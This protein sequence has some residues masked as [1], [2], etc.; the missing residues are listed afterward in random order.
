MAAIGDV[1]MYQSLYQTAE[2]TEFRK[3]IYSRD[4]KCLHVKRFDTF[5]LILDLYLK[6]AR[7]SVKEFICEVHKLKPATFRSSVTFKESN[8]GRVSASADTHRLTISL[9][10]IP[11]ETSRK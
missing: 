3:E 4:W 1:V 5:T 8:I 9:V 7:A 10:K 6:S 2:K 11:A